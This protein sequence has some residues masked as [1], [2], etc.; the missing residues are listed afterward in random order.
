MSS[1]I[2]VGL[3][4]VLSLS[5]LVLLSSQLSGDTVTSVQVR[6]IS[7]SGAGSVGVK[8]DIANATF[9]VET[10]FPTLQAALAENSKKMNAV[11]SKLKELGIAD[12][13]IQTVNFSV[14]VERPFDRGIPGPITGYRVN[15]SL[16]ATIRQLEKVGTV[17][18]QAIA[19]GANTVSGISFG[20]S[21]GK[22]LQSDARA[23][24]VADAKA[25]AEELAKAAG[26]TLGP[27]ISLQE[28]GMGIPQGSERATFAVAQ[29]S[30]PVEGGEL[31]VTVSVQVV[32]GIP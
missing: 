32:Y 14:N 1:K 12:R 13:D 2:V 27:V 29:S 22:A 21:A 23:K 19:S 17:I 9:G 31:T 3:A 15:N 4:A 8:P 26:I 6:T 16:R 28:T 30:V 11:I 25:K 20:T 24:A 10:F 5:L 7:V 18:D